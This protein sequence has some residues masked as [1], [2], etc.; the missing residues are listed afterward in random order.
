MNNK[1]HLVNKIRKL[2]YIFLFPVFFYPLLEN[3]FILL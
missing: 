3:A 2:Q 1:Y